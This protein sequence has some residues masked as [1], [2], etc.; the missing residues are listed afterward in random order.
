[1]I[2][3]ALHEKICAL[4]K[5]LGL[6]VY[7]ITLLKED[8]RYIFRI[9]ITHKAPM[10]TQSAAPITL[11]DCQ[12]L[13]ELVSPLLDV[14]DIGL[15]NYFLEVSSPGLERSLKKPSDFAFSLGEPIMLRLND[16]SVIEGILAHFDST[17]ATISV[18][19]DEAIA[20]IAL[21]DVKKAKVIY[22]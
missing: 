20:H 1:M 6:F 18:K 5:D 17:N 11:Q 3:E 4:A 15:D 9:A 10:Q 21:S 7:D 2:N 22:E 19:I 12:D 8:N 13:S 14:E 16:K